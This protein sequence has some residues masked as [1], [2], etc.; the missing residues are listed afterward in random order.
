MA[1][2]RHTAEKRLEE[3]K[4]QDGMTQDGRKPSPTSATHP[5]ANPSPSSAAPAPPTPIFAPLNIPL[6][7]RLETLCVLVLFTCPLWFFALNLYCLLL[8]PRLV[9]YPYLVYLTYSLFFLTAH[10]DDRPSLLS[11]AVRRASVFR[12]FSRYFPI[13]LSAPA[14]LPPAH[15]TIIGYHPH[16]IISIGAISAFATDVCGWPALSGGLRCSLVTLD[17]SFRLPFW[18]L[19]LLACGV[20]D[21]SKRCLDLLLARRDT[22][23]VI[24]LG[25]AKESL[26]AFPPDHVPRPTPRYGAAAKDTPPLPPH[27]ILLHMRHRKGF[28]RLALAHGAH[29][30]PAFGFGE[31]QLF[32][33]WA[34]PRGSWL[35]WAQDGVQ[36]VIGF[37]TPMFGGRGV[38]QYRWGVLPRRERVDVRM[39]EVLRVERVEEGEVTTEMVDEVHARYLAA[40]VALFE[41]HKGEYEATRDAT[42][43]FV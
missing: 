39:G 32:W 37:A 23:V 42:L 34:N 6:H 40:L 26:D 27:P 1:R 17:A 25:G 9:F 13:S 43:V 15:P 28:I 36:A 30:V 5:T 3:E 10:V 8:A 20:R 18:N 24:V 14:P 35:R 4:Q 7:R 38:F 21:S 19:L 11:P 12:L 2:E 33:Q 31:L 29:L 41:K 16:G 22:A